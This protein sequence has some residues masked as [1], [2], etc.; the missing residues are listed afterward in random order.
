[1]ATAKAAATAAAM[2]VATVA[3]G[4]SNSNRDSSRGVLMEMLTLYA[5][6]VWCQAVI[7]E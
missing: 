1:M 6:F 5:I 2:A 3:I 4:G 7:P